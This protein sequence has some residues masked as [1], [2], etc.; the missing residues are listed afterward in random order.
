MLIKR[1]T[2]CMVVTAISSIVILTVLGLDGRFFAQEVKPADKYFILNSSLMKDSHKINPQNRRILRK[3]IAEFGAVPNDAVDD[4]SAIQKTIDEVAR[5]GGGIVD[6]PKGVYLVSI[7]RK[8]RHS[9]AIVLHSNIILQGEGASQSIIKVADKQGN[10]E[11]IFGAESLSTPIK[12]L[13][14]YDLGI[15]GNGSKNPV[16]GELDLQA[17]DLFRYAVRIFVGEHIKIER[18]RFFNQTCV[19]TITV[20]GDTVKDVIISNNTFDSIGGGKADYDHSTIYAHGSQITITNNRFFSRSGSGTKGARAALDIHGSNHTITGNKIVGYLYGI[21]ATGVNIPQGSSRQL[22]ANNLIKGVSSGIILWSN[23]SGNHREG[24][25]LSN[26]VVR[27]NQITIDVEGWKGFFD[28]EPRSGIVFEPSLDAPIQNL[29]IINNRIRFTAGAKSSRRSDYFS[30]GITLW[31]HQYSRVPVIG[32][33]ILNNTIM[34]TPGPGMYFNSRLEDVQIM[35][36]TIMNTG[37][38]QYKFED[39]YRSAILI[40]DEISKV[41]IDANTFADSK[42]TMKFGIVM[43]SKCLQDCAAT[44]NQ[45]QIKS[46]TKFNFFFQPSDARNSQWVIDTINGR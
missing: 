40:S 29:S 28:E 31:E 9:P 15:D 32:M 25:A 21:H 11:T 19:N 35:G 45:T 34:N 14:I 37:Q 4:T 20:N 16:R 10:Y 1:E 44:R 33:K 3:S 39:I 23:Y 46:R 26:V 30:G 13:G 41:Q 24:S 8:A 18:N 5:A 12:N 2:I 7:N 6:I 43:L 42:S 38:S 36:N 17:V 22:Y 27:G